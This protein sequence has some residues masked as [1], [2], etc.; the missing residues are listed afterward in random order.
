MSAMSRVSPCAMKPAAM[1]TATAASDTNA[2]RGLTFVAC[3]SRWTAPT[4]VDI[5]GAMGSLRSWRR[6]KHRDQTRLFGPF[7]GGASKNMAGALRGRRAIGPVVERSAEHPDLPWR[8]PRA[9]EPAG[10][11]RLRGFAKELTASSGEG[12]AARRR[13]AAARLPTR[14]PSRKPR[15]HHR[16]RARVGAG[17]SAISVNDTP[18]TSTS[19]CSTKVGPH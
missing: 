5:E 15:H 16:H 2:T 11:S 19:C 4:P 6:P 18:P 12:H 3:L 7:G 8:R 13:S 9:P 10:L 17:A 1:A 14:D